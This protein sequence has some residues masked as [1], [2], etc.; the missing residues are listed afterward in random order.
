MRRHGLG[1]ISGSI[2]RQAQIAAELERRPAATRR[3][4][5]YVTVLDGSSVHVTDWKGRSFI[6]DAEDWENLKSHRFTIHP[7]KVCVVGVGEEKQT[8][9]LSRVILAPA[10]KDYVDHIDGNPTNNRRSNLRVCSPAENCWNTMISSNNSS[11][12]KGVCRAS[13]GRFRAYAT[14][15]GKS[16][17]LGVHP[18]PESAALAYDAF[19][20]QHFGRFACV[21]FPREGEQSVHRNRGAL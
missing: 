2:A 21:N 15:F 14:K 13:K 6:L 11:G 20:R 5:P 16:F 17:S 4:L 7:K 12:L 9:P 10:D 3:K 19:A 1:P 18:T 8:L